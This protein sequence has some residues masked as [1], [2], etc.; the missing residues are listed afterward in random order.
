MAE[1]HTAEALEPANQIL[2]TLVARWKHASEND[3][4]WFGSLSCVADDLSWGESVCIDY[5]H[6]LLHEGLIAE[7]PD[8]QFVPT[9]K[10][11]KHHAA[12]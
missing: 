11:T 2:G 5:I 12:L 8:G 6:D 4:Y 3:T 10:G 1:Q 7:M 9:A